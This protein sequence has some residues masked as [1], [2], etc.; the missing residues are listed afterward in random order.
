MQGSGPT[1]RRSLSLPGTQIQPS[2]DSGSG[3][4][5]K[6]RK[7]ERQDES[8]TRNALIFLAVM[9][10]LFVAAMINLRHNHGMPKSLD[11][12]RLRPKR[13]SERSLAQQESS[14]SDK[15]AFI[16]PHSLYGL[17][18]MDI[19]GKMVSLEKFNGMVT[20]I[21]NVACM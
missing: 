17:S 12:G 14:H 7:L 2:R 20:L 13:L 1:L 10:I 6:R 18:V 9:S 3:G 8:R 11:S 5:E 15:A 16:T 4:D 19:T 21:V